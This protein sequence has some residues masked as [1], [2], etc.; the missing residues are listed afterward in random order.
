MLGVANH[1][2]LIV[3]LDFPDRSAALKLV[4][5]VHD[6]VRTF[7]IGSELFTAEGPAIV[8]EIVSSGASV[9][10]DLKFHDIPNTVAGAVSSAARLGVAIMNVH[11]LGGVEM[12]RAAANA[13]TEYSNNGSGSRT[14]PASNRPPRRPAIIGVTVLTSMDGS[15]LGQVGITEA[16]HDEV[17]KL[18][19]LAEA[20]GL[21]G[22]VAS[23]HETR[24]IREALP[25]ENF[26]IVTPGIRPA[27]SAP[28]DQRRFTTP[29]EAI[30][31]GADYIVVGRPITASP[32]PRVAVQKIIEE[33]G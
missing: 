4:D 16:V 8:G 13:A 19:S 1:E 18:A 12:M 2:R 30:S 9:F 22:V 14:P 32:D 11:T 23:P 28:G 3:A 26:M 29:S 24:L 25:R 17:M 15:G 6:L 20:A 5:Q 27:W 31:Y 7:K 21:D 33:I 10:L